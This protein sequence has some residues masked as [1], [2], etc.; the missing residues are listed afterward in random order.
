MLI[1]LS[2]RLKYAFCEVYTMRKPL[3]AEK[4]LPEVRGAKKTG[5]KTC[6]SGDCRTVYEG[7]F[8]GLKALK[9]IAMNM[10]EK[11][12]QWGGSTR[13]GPE[14]IDLSKVSKVEYSHSLPSAANFVFPGILCRCKSMVLVATL[15]D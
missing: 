2:P 13:N 4:E 3:K 15:K 7:R 1:M 8:Q 9:M 11:T 5:L 12:C 14:I 10:A 6:L